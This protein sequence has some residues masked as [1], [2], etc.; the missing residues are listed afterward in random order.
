M[1]LGPSKEL[2]ALTTAPRTASRKV[3]TNPATVP[4]P[5]R[6]YYSNC[7]RVRAGSLLFISGQLGMDAT[8]KLVDHDD[9]AAQAEQALRNIELLLAANGASLIDVVKVTVYVTD[10]RHL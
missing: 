5:I 7:V 2:S 6:G 9:V 10:I 4:A 8:G 1:T 3:A